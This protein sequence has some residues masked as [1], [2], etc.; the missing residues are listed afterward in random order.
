MWYNAKIQN[1]TPSSYLDDNVESAS[2]ASLGDLRRDGGA[3]VFTATGRRKAGR[4]FFE[5][6]TEFQQASHGECNA[7]C[8][9]GDEP[10]DDPTHDHHNHAHG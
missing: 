9:D 10:C 4:M 1:I 7:G 6:F 2:G 8:C 3:Y 5:T